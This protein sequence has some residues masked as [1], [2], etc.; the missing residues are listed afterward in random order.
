M[1]SKGL[2]VVFLLLSFWSNAALALSIIFPSLESFCANL[3]LAVSPK[4]ISA[5][6]AAT[7]FG[8]EIG[9]KLESALETA[10]EIIQDMKEYRALVIGGSQV[11]PF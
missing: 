9:A 1:N 5:C 4:C 7:A 8:K 10:K 2:F 6:T 3:P 11:S